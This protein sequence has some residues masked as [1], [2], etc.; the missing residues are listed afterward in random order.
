MPFSTCISSDAGR[1]LTC[2]PAFPELP[3]R[4]LLCK[5]QKQHLP[6]LHLFSDIFPTCWSSCRR[7]ELLLHLDLTQSLLLP[8]APPCHPG[9]SLRMASHW[10][11][12]F[13]EKGKAVAWTSKWPAAPSCMSLQ[14]QPH[15]LASLPSPRAHDHEARF[16]LIQVWSPPVKPPR[17]TNGLIRK[18]WVHRTTRD[19]SLQ[20]TA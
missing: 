14:L 1:Y 3:P 7:E 16:Q 6:D 19:A 12:W 5:T 11:T 2:G 15:A 10:K 18:H 9:P 4:W 17:G 13:Q 8:G 20:V